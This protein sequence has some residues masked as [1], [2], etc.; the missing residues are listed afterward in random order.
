VETVIETDEIRNAM[1]AQRHVFS[2]RE[3]AHDNLRAFDCVAT[4]DTHRL[5]QKRRAAL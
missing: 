4:R 5:K 3:S 1:H 2:K